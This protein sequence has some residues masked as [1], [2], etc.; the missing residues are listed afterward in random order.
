M[1]GESWDKHK[2]SVEPLF[3]CINSVAHSHIN[4]SLKKKFGNVFPGE[5]EKSCS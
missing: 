3:M 2:I 4:S 5:N 1:E